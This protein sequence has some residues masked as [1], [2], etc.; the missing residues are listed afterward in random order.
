MVNS[1]LIAANTQGSGASMVS[2]G[3][4]SKVLSPSVMPAGTFLMQNGTL[5]VADGKGNLQPVSSE[6]LLSEEILLQKSAIPSD[7]TVVFKIMEIWNFCG[8]GV[9]IK[10][11]VHD[12]QWRMSKVD[13]TLLLTAF[14]RQMEGSTPEI[15][16]DNARIETPVLDLKTHLAVVF[17]YPD[18]SDIPYAM[19]MAGVGT[20][21][22]FFSAKFVDGQIADIRIPANWMVNAKD[23]LAATQIELDKYELLLS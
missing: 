7:A 13:N 4:S 3:M 1:T 2:N 17:E 14:H 20:F 8:K 21:G 19:S 5:R 11:M 6:V 10:L 18:W 15:I 12:S 22:S 23:V 16:L 9:Q